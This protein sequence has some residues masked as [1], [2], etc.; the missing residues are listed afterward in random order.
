MVQ[1]FVFVKEREKIAVRHS[2]SLQRHQY[3]FNKTIKQ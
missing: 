3:T 1:I 2:L